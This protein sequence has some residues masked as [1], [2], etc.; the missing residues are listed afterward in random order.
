MLVRLGELTKTEPWREMEKES[1]GQVDQ[2]SEMM[3]A[4]A[5]GCVEKRGTCMM[6]LSCG[7]EEGCAKSLLLVSPSSS[8]EC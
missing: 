5:S 4:A 2:R 1:Q 6:W 7:K 3:A 8:Q